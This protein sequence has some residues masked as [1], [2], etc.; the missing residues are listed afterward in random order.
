MAYSRNCELCEGVI[1][2]NTLCAV[3]ADG[4]LDREDALWV[5]MATI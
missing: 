3:P 2:G 4:G 1:G 5:W